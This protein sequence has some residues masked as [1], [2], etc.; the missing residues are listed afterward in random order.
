MSL[1][2]A[3]RIKAFSRLGEIM[4]EACLDKPAGDYAQSLRLL[5]ERQQSNNSWFTPFYVFESI[6]ALARLLN[7]ESLTAWLQTYHINDYNESPKRIGVIMAGNIPLVGFH[8]F[9]C[10]LITG[11][12]L[13]GKSSSKDSELIKAISSILLKLEPG[14][15]DFIILNEDTI[16]DPYAVIATGSNNT[17]RYFEYNYGQLPHIFRN[18][19]SSVAIIYSE[20]SDTEL[21]DLGKDVFYYYGLGCR[22]V[23]RLYLPLNFDIY[24]LAAAWK[25]Y[26]SHINT[27]PY[28]NNYYYNRA[29]FV[30]EETEY[31]DLDYLLLKKDHGYS[32]PVSVLY[33]SFYKNPQ[34]VDAELS[35]NPDQIQTIVGK[36]HTPFGT[37]QYPTLNDYADGIDTIDFLLNIS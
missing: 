1:R 34:E 36:G 30:T 20:I 32:S 5:A 3:K 11:N 6:S 9:L 4:M 28:R 33:Y 13:V 18:N 19:R 21:K 2:L 14:F 17:S 15:K 7:S 8:D 24:R 23:S 31:H 10:V 22:N 37:A 29:L 25:E 27:E 35:L 16:E 12:I 26:A